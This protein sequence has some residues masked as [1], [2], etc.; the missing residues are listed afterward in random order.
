[1]NLRTVSFA[2]GITHAFLGAYFPDYRFDS[3]GC[4]NVRSPRNGDADR[5]DTVRRLPGAFRCVLGDWSPYTYQLTKDWQLSVCSAT[6]LEGCSAMK[7]K[8]LPIVVILVL[9][10]AATAKELI[11]QGTWNTT[12]RKLDGVMTCV[13]TPVTKHEWRGRFYGIWQGVPFDYTVN[14]SGPPKTLSGTATVDGTTYEWKGWIN[15]ER[16]KANFGGDRYAGSFDLKR[17]ETAQI[18]RK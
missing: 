15:R 8:L 1:M 9:C 14:F 13:V 2:K 11:Y 16:F 3:R 7:T 5:L 17:M 4:W 12:N 6:T 10:S 18:A